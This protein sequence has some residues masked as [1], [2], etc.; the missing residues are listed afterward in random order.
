MGPAP[1]ADAPAS[2]SPTSRSSPWLSLSQQR[3]RAPGETTVV[4]DGRQ[5]WAVPG[6]W[7]AHVHLANRP[8]SKDRAAIWLPA[9]LA[10][11]IVGVRD[12]GGDW[13]T[14]KQLR[15]QLESGA[16]DGPDIIAPG[17]FVDGAG[18]PP[19]FIAV[20]TAEEARAAVR[21]PQLL[22]SR[23]RE[24]PGSA[25]SG[26]VRLDRGRGPKR[27]VSAWPDTSPRLCPRAT[28]SPRARRPSS[29]SPRLFQ[30]TRR[31]FSH[32]LPREA[33]LREQLHAWNAALA[34]A[35]DPDRKRLREWQREIPSA[36]LEECDAGRLD[37][38]ADALVQRGTAVV[39]TL[40]WSQTVRPLDADSVLPAGTPIRLL[41][42]EESDSL[43]ERR[44]AYLEAASDTALQLNRAMARRSLRLVGT[45]HDAGVPI[46]AGTDSFDGFVLPGDSLH[47]EIE[48]LVAAGLDAMDAI[49]AATEATT[50]ILGLQGRGTIEA[51]QRADIVLLEADPAADVANLRRIHAVIKGGRHYS[52][53]A[54]DR[55]LEDAAAKAAALSPLPRNDGR[56][57][58]ATEAQRHG[59]RLA[60]L[61]L[62]SQQPPLT[63]PLYLDSD[64]SSER[65][66]ARDAL[67]SRD[68]GRAWG[69]ARR[70]AMSP[71]SCVGVNPNRKAGTRRLPEQADGRR[72]YE[73]IGPDVRWYRRFE[74]Q[75][76]C[77]STPGARAVLRE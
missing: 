25:V 59:E 62:C 53:Q 38:L 68:R 51:G 22:G 73:Q 48:L 66:A 72:A 60:L 3:G 16:I 5:L 56:Q 21:Q 9:L 58:A 29:T 8:D 65:A 27:R 47:R 31:C 23:L 34:R 76:G 43:R 26:C 50:R 75:V 57:T 63:L 46:L 18:D 55:L 67:R 33:E 69:A 24:D 4:I 37:A 35:P 54:L 32:A 41:T 10:H 7:D 30:A 44:Q 15:A 11:G 19:N 36:L 2:R 49:G 71:N 12:M 64:G 1:P 20:T 42:A 61:T 13:E 17:P 77:R 14:V 52:R 28:S 74:G 6:L 45:L 40:V 39:P 70:F